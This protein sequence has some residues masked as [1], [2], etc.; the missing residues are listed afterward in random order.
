MQVPSHTALC[1]KPQKLASS[2]GVP[3]GWA[4]THL[5]LPLSLPASQRTGLHLG[6]QCTGFYEWL[7][8]TCPTPTKA[9]PSS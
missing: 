9:A 7:P 6:S 4:C 5:Q 1:Q 2:A 3:E 8:K